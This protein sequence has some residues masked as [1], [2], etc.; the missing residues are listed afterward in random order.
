MWYSL[1]T[2]FLHAVHAGAINGHPGVKRTRSKLQEIAYWKGWTTDVQ[3]CVQRCHICSTH[4]PGPCRKQGQMQMQ[5][6]LAC[7]V[8]HKVHVDLVGPFPLSKKGFWY[9]LTAICGFIKYLLCVPIRD[10]VS[11]TV[12]DALVRHLYL[13]YGPPEIL[14]HDR[15]GELWSDIMIHLTELLDIQPSKITSHRPNSNGVIERVHRTLHSMFGK[16]VRI[17]KTGASWYRIYH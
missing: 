8:M 17:K 12:A 11:V 9:L 13:V 5:Q 3:A 6:A 16:L 7:D 1:R 2:A 4:H 14:V 15:G 10:E